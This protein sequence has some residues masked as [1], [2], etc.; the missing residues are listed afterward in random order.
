MGLDLK[1]LGRRKKR[2]VK[3]SV[4]CSDLDVRSSHNTAQLLIGIY[5]VSL[6]K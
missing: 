1:G 4:G 6:K 5:T 3:V 2:F